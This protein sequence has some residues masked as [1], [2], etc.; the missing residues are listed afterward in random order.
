[1]GKKTKQV[2]VIATIERERNI[3]NT[4]NDSSWENPICQRDR[5]LNCGR[6]RLVRIV[7]RTRA[8]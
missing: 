1:M 4:N 7:C 6:E 5:A 8:G 3:H 2:E